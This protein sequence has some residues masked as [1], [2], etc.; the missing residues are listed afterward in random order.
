MALRYNGRNQLSSFRHDA[1]A[2]RR[3]I[4]LGILVLIVIVVLLFFRAPVTTGVRGVGSFVLAPV[5]STQGVLGG[6]WSAWATFFTSKATLREEN[7]RLH[8][9]V[10]ELTEG[11]LA[12]VVI[13]AEWEAQ[14]TLLGR[15]DSRTYA[16]AYVL[17]RPPVSP[18]DTFMIDLGGS[19]GIVPGMEI[20]I[21]HDVVIGEVTHTTAHTALVTLYSSPGA[22][23]PAY[24]GASTTPVV[25]HGIGG[26]NLRVSLPKGAVVGTSTVLY[27]PGDGP[28][29]L[30]VLAGV[31]MKEGSSFAN[32]TFVL[33][34]N[35]LNLRS[36]YVSLTR[37]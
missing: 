31:D 8:D 20:Y 28:R 32:Y 10:R 33:P 21:S 4:A 2:R 37:S 30:G 16:L 34:T 12:D 22:E 36:V 14:R 18:F 35:Y 9:T 11:N 3:K 25:V 23:F 6:W 24:L 17:A 19:E 26:G 7:E 27:A 1:T 15:T 29:V 5:W 13:R